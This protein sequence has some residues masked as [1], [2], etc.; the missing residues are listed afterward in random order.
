MR[1]R[2][3]AA[4]CIGFV[5]AIGSCG[6]RALAAER[7]GFEPADVDSSPA[8][9]CDF[10]S[11][12]D[13]I[14]VGTVVGDCRIQP[15]GPSSE[16]FEDMPP[17]NPALV[18]DGKGDYVRIVDRDDGGFDFGLGDAIT[19][20]AW[21]RTAD[22]R[23]GRNVYI[24]GKGRTHLGK[25]RDNQNYALRLRGVDGSACV[26]FLFRSTADVGTSPGWHRWTSRVGFFPDDRWHHVAV[27]YR[28]GEPDS[29]R[30]Y[31]DGRQVAGGWDMDGATGRGP[32]VD[33]DEIWIGSS[34]G[35]HPGSSL[36]GALDKVQIHRRVVAKEEMEQRYKLVQRPPPVPG[37]PADDYLSSE[38]VSV[39]LYEGVASHTSWPSRLEHPVATY[40][41]DAF[42]FSQ[43]ATPYGRDGV[44]RDWN[45]TVL[46]TA[47]AKVDLPRGATEW[48][49]RAAGMTRLWID[50]QLVIR[51]PAHLGNSN[52]H[53]Q[54]VPHSTD[55]PWLRP[56]G[57]GHHEVKAVGNLGHA[58]P[59]RVAIETMIGGTNLR[60]EIG[61]LLVAYRRDAREPWRVL[62]VREPFPLTDQGWSDWSEGFR[63]NLQRINDQRRRRSARR[64]DDLWQKRHEDARTFARNQ[65]PLPHETIDQYVES[66]L[67]SA[68]RSFERELVDDDAFI[69]R[70]FLD[71]TGV[72][73]K[74]T[75]IE[76]LKA[77]GGDRSRWVDVVVEDPRWA[78]HWTAYWMDVL[79]ENPNILKAS[80]N[81]TGPFRWY[82]YDVLRDNVAVDRWVTNL[83]RMEGS[84]RYGG[85][86]GFALATQNDVPMAAKAHVIASAMLG[87]NMKCARCHD[88][89]YH[90]WT[91]RD[92]FSIAAMLA[93]QPIKVP[94][95]STVPDEFFAGEEEN[96]SLITATLRPGATV[97]PGWPL[98][99]GGDPGVA[100]SPEDV[101][102]RDRLAWHVTRPEN[103]RFAQ[104]IVNRLWKRLLGDAIVE[105]VDDWEGARPS[106][107]ELLSFLARELIAHDYDF[108][109]VAR[110]I[111]CSDA[112]QRPA[113]D[114]EIIRDEN[115]R[116][117]DAPRQRRMTAEQLVDSMHV[118]VG[119]AMDAGELTFDPEARMK[120]AA[121]TS[122]G[123]PRRAWQF[124]SLSNERDRP[125]LSLPRASA[126]C[127]CLESFGW[128]GARQEPI[129]HRPDQANVLQPA[130]LSSGLLSIQLTRLT[131]Q[132]ELTDVCIGADSPEQLV[133]E[134][135]VR[136]LGRSP[137]KK[138]KRK[139]TSL[140]KHGFPSRLLLSPPLPQT[141]VREPLVSWANHLNPEATQIRLRQMDRLRSGPAPSDRLTNDWR[142]RAEDA[143]WA[144]INTPEFQFVP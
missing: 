44:R 33:D 94:A 73:P 11:I 50:D 37:D 79:A 90:D 72:I 92:L 115:Q 61:E 71:C 134:L 31:L 29:V 54:V 21:V 143:V 70:L 96:A 17:V 5:A 64:E 93:G 95:T 83:I 25:A 47:T 109:H 34:M 27:T 28:F 123:R 32:V 111:L 62:S 118:A 63:S 129:N 98:E 104:T 18:L 23:N 8:L 74:V 13:G 136:F 133:G 59:K 55:D 15:V 36:C 121:L 99:F 142:E 22:I 128:K 87:V 26:S 20:E 103:E 4:V 1:T 75:E 132:H 66:K 139:F 122:L 114:R 45:G 124:A 85:P 51:T 100:N 12:D 141:P 130:I 39:A 14:A 65:P 127:E 135:F 101:T 6:P 57:P 110:L 19:I 102:A 16:Y 108:K 68:G 137:T 41:Q 131:D 30:G 126:V 117:F 69:R 138:E 80:L 76:S 43:I 113:V 84:S 88:A 7:S 3:A 9:R 81:N 140:L 49:V 97:E 82:L 38:F 53:G 2:A 42:A 112:Y 48:M 52:G 60:H 24:I 58:G 35:G 78:D 40:R 106:H 56:P 77:L 91:Q 67:R 46:M 86:A 89:P 107:P 119:L 144:L 125:A 10:E 105:P 120:P 116:F